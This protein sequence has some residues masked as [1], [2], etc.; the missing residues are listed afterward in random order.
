MLGSGSGR[1]I[2][3]RLEIGPELEHTLIA[4]GDFV[5]VPLARAVERQVVNQLSG[6]AAGLLA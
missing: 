4:V 1:G 5:D 2:H 6:D 3:Q